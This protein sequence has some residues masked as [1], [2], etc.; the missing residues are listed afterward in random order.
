MLEMKK[1]SPPS[2]SR[3]T[4]KKVFNTFILLLMIPKSKKSRNNAFKWGL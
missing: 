2:S 1:V 3:L 4:A